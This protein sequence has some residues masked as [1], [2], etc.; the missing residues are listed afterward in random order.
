MAEPM[1]FSESLANLEARLGYH[2]QDREL[3]RTAL[4]HR[5]YIHEAPAD[6]RDELTGL[7]NQRLEFLGD[8]VL[9]FCVSATLYRLFPEFR[10][11]ELSKMRAGLVNDL[12]LASLAREIGVASCLSLGRGE[13]T[14][15]GRDKNSILADAFEAL[16]AAIYLDGGIGSALAAVE[17]LLGELIARSSTSDL[18][19]D[20][21]TG[22]QEL[23]QELFNQVPVYRLKS[24]DGPDHARTFR[25]SLTIGDQEMAVGQGP[26]KK[27]AERAAA[28]TA[29]S[30]LTQLKKP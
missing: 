28:K 13:E 12:Q 15:G 30:I 16:L 23:T 18:L 7:D 19:M 22:L 9:S 27:E 20:Y 21:K 24:A 1:E 14:S 3:L 26:S 11:G 17:R 8:A 6:S 10:E 29:L 4:R 5:S 2:F 25:V